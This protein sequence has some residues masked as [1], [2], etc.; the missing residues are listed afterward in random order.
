[1]LDFKLI[2]LI[3]KHHLLEHYVH[4]PEKQFVYLSDLYDSN[5]WRLKLFL[6]KESKCNILQARKASK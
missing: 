1:M 5:T 4:Y 2:H 6:P 3:L